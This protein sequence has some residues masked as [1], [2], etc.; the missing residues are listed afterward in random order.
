MN[1]PLALAGSLAATVGILAGSLVSPLGASSH[2]EAPGI[3]V[4]PCADN[5]DVY[6]FV[7]PD[8]PDTVTLLANY[9]PLQHPAGGPNFN[10]FCDDVLYEINIDNKGDG[11]D[12][13]KYQFR[14]E[15][16][17]RNPN[18][19]LYN[20]GQITTL[21]DQDWNQP[22]T[23]SVTRIE[24]G[25]RQVLAENLK[26]PPVNVGPRSTPNYDSLAAMAVQSLPGNRKVFAG[27]RDD[28]FYV[29]LGSVFDLAGL[30][31]FN[32]AHLLPRPAST[33]IDSVAGFNVHTIALQVPITD[34]TRDNK[35]PKDASDSNA[36]IGVYASA[37][38][39]R[40]TVLRDSGDDFTFGDWVQVSRLG[41]PLINEVLIPL[42]RKDRWNR[43]DP[44]DDKDFVQF[45]RKP[46][47][48]GLVNLLYPG[49]PDVPTMN[50]DDLVTVLLTG[51]PGIN[52][53]PQV[54]QSDHLRLNMAIA[55][56]NADP[57]LDNRLG[58]VAGELSGFPNGRRLADDIVDIELRAVACGYGD[59]LA[60]NLGLCN[61]SPNNQLGDGVD[62]NDEPL[63]KQFPYVP[64]PHQGYEMNEFSDD[65]PAA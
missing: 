36:V 7:S 8:K 39:Q 21:D 64:S 45:Y 63:L 30:R 32:P 22:Q 4:D 57:N 25:K 14:F 23:Y 61:L 35:M 42:G 52:Q 50:R 15:T 24:D 40:T 44:D 56:A 19:F 5:T 17:F 31:P 53:L 18:S 65:P 55:P 29:D 26:T 59:F 51:I 2:R 10:A 47:L 38:R 12:H 3:S 37:S 20:T 49:L 13:I 34:L 48:A 16:K 60:K 43:S 11:E 6:A 54:T 33:G 46:E 58:A 27:Q 1:R 9:I 41:E 62:G 28:P